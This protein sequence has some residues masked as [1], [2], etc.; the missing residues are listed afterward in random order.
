MIRRQRMKKVIVI[1]AGIGGLSAAIRLQHEGFDVE[2][3]E[4]G[5]QPGGKMH[6]IRDNGF[7]FDIGP[8]IVMM[9]EIYRDVFR[10]ANK[11]P[12][13]YI[14]MKRL[15]PMYDVFFKDKNYRH[16]EVGSDL[17]SLIEMAEKMG[18]GNAQGLLSYL[19]DI[20][21]RY[22]VA[23][24]HFITRPFRRK[25]DMYNLF[26]LRQALKLKTLNSADKMMSKYIENKDLQQMLSFQTLYIGV[27]PKKGPSLYNIIPMIELLYGVWFIEGGMHTMALKMAELFTELGGTIH[28]NK[29]V[30]EIVV[31]Q[32]HVEGVYVD[33]LH[34]KSDIVLSNADFPYTM[35]HL[36]KDSKTR[37]K[38]TDKKI[39][40][41]DYSCSCLIFYWGVKGDYSN[42][43]VH[44]FVICDDLDDNLES[45][46]DGRLLKDPSMYL[47]I[48]SNMDSN[49][50]PEGHAAFYLLMPVSEMGT[51]KYDYNEETIEYY[52]RKAF[53]T[54]KGIEGLEDIENNLVVEH[55][56]TPKDFE[57]NFNAYRGATFG[58]QPTLL[59]SNHFRPQSK[60]M[61]CD[62]LYFTGSSTHPGAGVPI[63]IEGGRIA[64]EEIKLDH[65][66]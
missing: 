17:K 63:V 58:L 28:Y 36:I 45:I 14:P 61:N 22:Q 52:R 15:E 2:I 27:S 55:V 21:K 12:D 26:M 6:Q 1:G 3:Y 57:A 11:N 50:A 56:Y 13:D 7:T 32:G 10:V 5:D 38:Y 31:N 35:K 60:S 8:T 41:M 66:V 59:Q 46:F 62:G 42:H 43:K 34:I 53:E 51:A 64:F 9:P 23:L 19:D 54:L 4:M 29:T 40:A 24:K 30:E 44:N 49:M 48:P 47:H 18:E 16:Y 25:R 39:D 33:G 20:Y 65:G 37:G